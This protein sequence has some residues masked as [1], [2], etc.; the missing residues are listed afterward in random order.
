MLA[1]IHLCEEGSCALIELLDQVLRH[2]AARRR[3]RW[4]RK[5]SGPLP[6]DL[7]G[8][9]VMDSLCRTRLGGSERSEPKVPWR[10]FQSSRCRLRRRL[11]P[12]PRTPLESLRG[13]SHGAA[14][15]GV[16]RPST[17][18]DLRRGHPPAAER[19]CLAGPLVWHQIKDLADN[20]MTE[21]KQHVRVGSGARGGRERT[22]SP[23]QGHDAW[24]TLCRTSQGKSAKKA[25]GL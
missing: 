1:S 6:D 8:S 3:F 22:R 20:L 25:L 24:G 5:P 18:G 16:F 19:V 21:G 12:S 11:R 17:T 4:L 2:A 9:G 13:A 15:T 10:P 7:Y 23:L 14:S